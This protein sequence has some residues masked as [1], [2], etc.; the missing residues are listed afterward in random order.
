VFVQFLFFLLLVVE[1]I[2]RTWKALMIFFSLLFFISSICFEALNEFLPHFDTSGKMNKKELF[3][4]SLCAFFSYLNC[5]S[6]KSKHLTITETL[7]WINLNDLL[8]CL[9]FNFFMHDFLFFFAAQLSSVRADNW[10]FFF[11]SLIFAR[12]F[13]FFLC[14]FSVVLQFRF[15][16]VSSFLLPFGFAH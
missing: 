16:L 9:Q 7:M 3:Q 8:S 15:L 1:L 11:L 14:W 12:I 13:P 2:W 5:P 4:L 10:K 6:N